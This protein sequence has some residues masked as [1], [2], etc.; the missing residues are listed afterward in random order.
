MAFKLGEKNGA[1]ATR[2]NINKP[3]VN[4]GT[5][6][7]NQQKETRRLEGMKQKA[8]SITASRYSDAQKAWDIAKNPLTAFGYAARG[9]RLP[10]NFA[11]GE[12]NILDNVMDIVNPASYIDSG[13]NAVKSTV[14]A[15][16]NIVKGELK[17]AGSDLVDAGI[18][19]LAAAPGAIVGGKAA[20]KGLNLMKGGKAP[21][22]EFAKVA[23]QASLDAAKAVASSTNASSSTSSM[24]HK[25]AVKLGLALPE[26]KVGKGKK[27]LIKTYGDQFDTEGYSH[28][29]FY[30]YNTKT[31]DDQKLIFGRIKEAEKGADD[32]WVAK[33][34][35]SHNAKLNFAASEKDESF[36][37][38]NTGSMQESED[39]IK[40]HDLKN[41]SVQYSKPEQVATHA[42][43]DSKYNSDINNRYYD[44]KKIGNVKGKRFFS[45]EVASHLE[46]AVKKTKLKSDEVLQ[47]GMHDWEVKHVYRG[48]KRVT[49]KVNFSD[50]EP[51]DVW[52]PGSFVSTTIN[53]KVS[54]SFGSIQN[55]IRAPKGQSVM[56][57]NATEVGMY[58]TE[59]EVIL[60]SKLRFQ[61]THKRHGL[62]PGGREYYNYSHKIVNPYTVAG[63]VG[64]TTMF[65]T[66]KKK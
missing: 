26:D 52:K 65:Q 3:K 8:G 42:F 51:G 7:T 27:E 29:P 36:V 24:S 6:M 1:L 45:K 39:F 16:K 17:K 15:G 34:K 23:T 19:A 12:R 44:P 58:P 59:R 66:S 32:R 41:P 63:A 35:R 21:S 10:N 37:Q 64:G 49:D 28:K 50:L 18:N 57:T 33:A 25:K 38:R 20:K 54:Q 60:P 2:D 30:K 47:T 4:I 11:K 9:E 14:S 13:I 5:P 55:K 31:Y 46:N 61:V 48:G 22:R 43:T 62:D 40:K 53:D 56:F